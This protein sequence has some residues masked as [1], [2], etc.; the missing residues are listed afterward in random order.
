MK[1][2]RTF[3]FRSKTK[4]SDEVIRKCFFFCEGDETEPIYFAKLKDLRSEIRI[5]S[6]IDF[7]QIEKPRGEDWSNPKKMIDTLCIDLSGNIT[8]NTLINAM[9]DSLYSSNYLSKHINCIKEF[10]D[11]L[12]EFMHKVLQVNATDIVSNVNETVKTTIKYFEESRPRICEIILNNVDEML[13]N[14]EITYAK[15]FDILCLVVDRDPDSFKDWQFDDVLKT[16]KKNNF[17]FLISNP[18]FEFWLLL[19]FDE[20][21]NIDKSK[22]KENA[23][24]NPTSKSSVR[25]IQSELRRIMGRYKKN[26]YNSEML[27]RE[28]DT[29]IKNERNFSED[30]DELK[31]NIGSNIGLFIEELRTIK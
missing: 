13:K 24:I 27:V 22:I 21:M 15:D 28:I 25:F 4:T 30:V 31:S 12:D 19:H 8:Y 14:Y 23:K 17:K 6:I 2:D 11:L 7:I 29:A 10:N 5:P 20:V 1:E 9:V 16:C 18:N 3:G 26:N